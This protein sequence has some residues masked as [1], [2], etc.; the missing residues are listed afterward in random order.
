MLSSFTAAITFSLICWILF[1]VSLLLSASFLISS[2][3]TAK[4]FPASP[5]L[6]ASMEAFNAS[7]FVWLDIDNISFVRFSTCSTLL[8]LSMAFLSFSMISPIISP[9]VFRL[10]IAFCSS[11]DALCCISFEYSNIFSLDFSNSSTLKST[12]PTFLS[13]VINV[14][15]TSCID[16]DNCCITADTSHE[17]SFTRVMLFSTSAKLSLSPPE[18]LTTSPITPCKTSINLFMPFTRR[19]ISSLVLTGILS[20]RLPQLFSSFSTTL[21]KSFVVFVVGFV[22]VIIHANTEI[23]LMISAITI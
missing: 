6:A 8:L 12:S 9:V 3:T 19:P 15:D 5:A 10:S 18:D 21:S 20:L 17:L 16:A 14:A 7:K 11:S 13:I 2:A 1:A 4:P 23:R 22:M